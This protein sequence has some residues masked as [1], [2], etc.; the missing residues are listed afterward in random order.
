MARMRLRSGLACAALAAALGGALG[1]PGRAFGAARVIGGSAIQIQVAPWTVFVQQQIGSSRLLCTGSIIDPSHV[2][3]AAP[4][5][6]PAT[7]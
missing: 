4:L 3:R 2:V 5:G 6:D 7:R 1:D